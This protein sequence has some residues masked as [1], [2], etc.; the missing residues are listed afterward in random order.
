MNLFINELPN[1]LVNSLAKE[2]TFAKLV[3]SVKDLKVGQSIKGKVLEILPESKVV[4]DLNGKKVI[5]EISGNLTKGQS[6]HVKVNSISPSIILNVFP[7]SS[8]PE[9]SAKKVS[10]K[11][12]PENPKK[13]PFSKPSFSSG[14][15]KAK[16]QFKLIPGH[17]FQGTAT[18]I[19]RSGK[20][21]VRIQDVEVTAKLPPASKSISVGE[22]VLIKA[23][24]NNRGISFEIINKKSQVSSIDIANLKNYLPAKQ[25]MGKMLTG[26]ESIFNENQ[27]LSSYKLDSDVLQRLRDTIKVLIPRDELVPNST[28]LKEQIDRSG[29]N[30]EAK[31]KK[32]IDEGLI[33]DKKSIL[34][35]DL[36]GQLLELQTKL[37]KFLL[38]GAEKLTSE[39]QRS[40]FETIQCTKLASDNIE[41][42]QLSNQLSKQEHNPLVLQIPDPLSPET[43]TAKLFIREGEGNGDGKKEEKND[44]HMVFLLNLSLIGDIR[45]DAKL[46]GKKISA[47]FTS[48]DKNVVDLIGMG[49]EDLRGKFDKLGFS[50]SIKAS[51]KDKLTIEME[52]SIEEVLKEVPLRL[53]DI[54]T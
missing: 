32:A 38:K 49:K 11:N 39:M 24:S 2:Q 15:S 51:Q 10:Q 20:I 18:K 52:N 45:I 5:A 14:T 27:G 53:V 29:I 12:T 6:I 22:S 3:D 33:L 7:K 50:A 36:K 26:L 13:V 54:K 25:D 35:M 4:L 34:S 9:V 41:L 31:I 1:K 8:N 30:Y 40:I 44:F 46:N 47:D 19:L 16:D 17:T 37:E 43:K 21:F 42:Q 23:I 28:H 48:E